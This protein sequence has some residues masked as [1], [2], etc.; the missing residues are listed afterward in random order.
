MYMGHLGIALAAKGARRDVSLLVLCLAAIAPDLVDF[1][2]EGLGHVA[3]GGLWSHSLA[4]MVGYGVLFAL[5]YG[6]A[7]H[8]LGAA[9]LVG[10]VA[11]SHVLADLV[12]SRMVLWRGGPPLGL[13][14]YIHPR[15]DFLV[16]GS[17]ILIGWWLYGTSLPDKRRF[18]VEAF[19]MLVVLLGLQAYMATLSIT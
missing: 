19:G 7:T 10:A 11:S 6:T 17:V 18:S 13:H 5:C 2:L 15:L 16:E 14:L 3:G 12:T 8:R 4:A 9:L 1:S